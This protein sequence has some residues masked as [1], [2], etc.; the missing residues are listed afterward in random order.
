MAIHKIELLVDDDDY[1]DIQAEFYYR[2]DRDLPDAEDG[3]NDEGRMLGE[4][5]RDLI[6]YRGLWNLKQKERGM[7]WPS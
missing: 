5:V 2:R 4:I 1:R 6:E 3:A 7:K